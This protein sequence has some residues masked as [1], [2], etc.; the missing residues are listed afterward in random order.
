MSQ[1]YLV[2][3]VAQVFGFFVEFFG[4]TESRI[5]KST[6]IRVELFGF[7]FNSVSFASCTFEALLLGAY[8]IVI[9][10]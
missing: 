6:I 3:S 4:C 10:Y 9:S 1:V 2:Y 5:L 7:P 8:I